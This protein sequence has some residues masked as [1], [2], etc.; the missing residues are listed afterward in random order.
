M[1]GSA[2]LRAVQASLTG[3]SLP[4]HGAALYRRYAA[5]LYWQAL[6]TYGDPG[7]AE[8]VVCDVLVDEYAL[9]ADHPHA[10]RRPAEEQE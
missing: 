2:K 6:R 1:L 3:G 4:S 5:A 8:Q 7:L 10:W 9:V